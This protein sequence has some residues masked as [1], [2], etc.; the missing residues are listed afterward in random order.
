LFAERLTD[1]TKVFK[2]VAKGQLFIMIE[3]LLGLV[4]FPPRTAKT[5]VTTTKSI[6]INA[7]LFRCIGEVGS[8]VR[9]EEIKSIL[10]ILFTV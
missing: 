3:E 10:Q 8:R 5:E 4:G 6:I 9:V 1:I 7:K 2:P